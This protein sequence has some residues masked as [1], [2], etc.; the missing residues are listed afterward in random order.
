MRT[1]A[2]NLIAGVARLATGLAAA[3]L[4]GGPAQALDPAR[5]V[6]QYHHTAWT[7]S[8]GIPPNIF[9]IA[10]TRDGFLW[11][12]SGSGLFRFD[13]VRAE[14]VGREELARA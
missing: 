14:A 12:G 9:A 1:R 8:D 7:Y 13:G 6:T 3:L 10:Q 11:L 5:L 4:V 2:R